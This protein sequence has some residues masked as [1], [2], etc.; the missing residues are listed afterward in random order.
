MEAYAGIEA[1]TRGLGCGGLAFAIGLQAFSRRGLSFVRA[2]L[3]LIVR[4]LFIGS[5]E[6]FP[7]EGCSMKRRIVTSSTTV[8]ETVQA[9]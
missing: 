7:L 6:S 8:V 2:L 3:F 5:S 1:V 4:G 9:N